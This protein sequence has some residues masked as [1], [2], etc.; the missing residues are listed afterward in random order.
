MDTI[1]QRFLQD[2]VLT[3]SPAQRVVMLYDRLG[4]DLARATAEATEPVER[5]ASLSHASQIVAELAGSLDL[6]AG[7]PAENLAALYG[8]MLREIVAA[9]ADGPV[10]SLIAVADSVRSL[11]A[12]WATVALSAASPTPASWTA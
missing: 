9:P 7:G 10:E 8:W 5:A 11:R 1:R 3:A 12:A 2:R 6:T 4:L